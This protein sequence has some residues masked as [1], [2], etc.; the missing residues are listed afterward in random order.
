MRYRTLAERVTA[1]RSANRLTNC[2]TH[3]TQ[4]P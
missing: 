3:F 2:Q 4:S 1:I